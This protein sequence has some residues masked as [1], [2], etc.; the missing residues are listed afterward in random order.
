MRTGLC[1]PLLLLTGASCF[2]AGLFGKDHIK[3][4]MLEDCE[5][6]STPVACQL[7]F[8][9]SF[10]VCDPL[11][12]GKDENYVLEAWEACV[13]QDRFGEDRELAGIFREMLGV[14]SPQDVSDLPL[15]VYPEA[16]M[17]VHFEEGRLD[18]IL[19]L[20]DN[21]SLAVATFSSQDSLRVIRRFY[22]DKLKG[23]TLVKIK[24]GYIFIKGK[25]PVKAEEFDMNHQAHLQFLAPREHVFI[26]HVD[27][28]DGAGV[29]IQISYSK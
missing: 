26:E 23:F 13:M 8:K 18:N 17:M 14:E 5:L 25:L 28:L 6:S 21:T 11:F 2:A 10:H 3:Q 9:K 19:D 7:S 1:L 22:E 15:P 12:S 4:E 29:K 16:A 27:M 20:K 24:Q